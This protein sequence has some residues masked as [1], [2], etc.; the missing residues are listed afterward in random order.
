MKSTAPGNLSAALQKRPEDPFLERRATAAEE[1]KKKK[2]WGWAVQYE[3]GDGSVSIV[4]RGQRVLS[5][6]VVAADAAGSSR[7]CAV[8][9]STA[10][11]CRNQFP[12]T[13]FVPGRVL[14]IFRTWNSS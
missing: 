6:D 12:C 8:K 2:R 14:A 9:P 3:R 11:G 4:L 13:G 7:R 5:Y 1:K 10:S